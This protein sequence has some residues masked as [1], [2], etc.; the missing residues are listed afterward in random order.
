M[1]YEVSE[2]EIPLHEENRF[3]YGDLLRIEEEEGNYGKQL[4]W[5]IHIDDEFYQDDEGTEQPR[6]TWA[7]CGPKLTTHENNK[8][9]KFVKGLLGREPQK[10]ELFDERHYTKEFYQDNPG[11][12]PKT[13]TGKAEPWRVA[14]MFEHAKKKSDG[15]PYDK[16][17]LIAAEDQIK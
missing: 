8:F 17:V 7:Y 12:D 4:K 6:V 3:F 1:P 2:P 15:T 11:E 5:F 16:V 13:L 14:V 9:R 10:G